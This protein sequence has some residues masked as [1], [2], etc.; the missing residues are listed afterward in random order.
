MHVET[1]VEWWY[2]RYW[3]L[4]LLNFFLILKLDVILIQFFWSCCAGD[5]FY[6]FFFGKSYTVRTES[7]NNDVVKVSWEET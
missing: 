1:E 2:G 4:D 7:S 3:G 5:N 6:I